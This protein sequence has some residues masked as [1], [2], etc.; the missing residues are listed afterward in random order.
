MSRDLV[1]IGEKILTVQDI[2]NALVT[3]GPILSDAADSLGIPRY[4]LEACLNANQHLNK[5]YINE[6][7]CVIDFA[8]KNIIEGV[9][10]KNINLSQ[11]VLE[12]LG[13][14]RGFNLKTELVLTK[15]EPAIEDMTTEEI[16]NRI[17][18]INKRFQE[19]AKEIREQREYNAKALAAKEARE[20]EH[21]KHTFKEIGDGLIVPVYEK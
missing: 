5:V 3:H 17:L 4:E 20:A 12:R 10:G 16:E 14:E 19:H 21:G 9:K 18:E 7:E 2:E 8:Y 15:I 13:R 6:V 11:W 1:V